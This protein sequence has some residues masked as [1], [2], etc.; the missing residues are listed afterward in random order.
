[1]EI[2]ILGP[3]EV[4]VAGSLVSVPR[5]QA[6]L[7]VAL[8]ATHANQV[9]SVGRITDV[10]W[11]GEPPVTFENQIQVHIRT[12]RRLALDGAASDALETRANLGYRLRTPPVA[13]DL[14]SWQRQVETAD[15][16]AAAG[17]LAEAAAAYRRALECWRGPA[18][19]GLRGRFAA[20]EA[21]VLEEGRM[22]VLL[23]RLDLELRL[24]RYADL[25]A[26]LTA[27]VQ[28]HPPHEG[29]RCRLM[30][31]LYGAGRAAEALATYRAGSRLL[32]DEHGV[33][34]GE[35]L[36][37]TH[38]EILAGAPVTQVVAG[39]VKITAPPAGPASGPATTVPRQLPAGASA[40]TGRA[41]D[42]DLLEK[43]ALDERVDDVAPAAVVAIVGM[44]GVGKTALAVRFGQRVA[45][46]FPDGQL[47]LDL[48]GHDPGTAMPV[49]EAL[50]RC[51]RA[52]G[53]Q[54]AAI[55]ADPDEAAA[56]YRSL[57]AGRRV[58]VVLDN[59]V[60]ADQVRP[61][62]PCTATCLAVV[63]SRHRLS[64]LV[65]R[66]GARRVAVGPLAAG[67]ALSLLR[68]IGGDHRTLAEPQAAA[69]LVE[70]TAGLPLALRIVAEK[71]A[72][73]P[74]TGLAD[75]VDS[76][77][78]PHRRLD[79][80]ATVDGD[81]TT[82]VRTAFSW[83]YRSLPADAASTYRTLGL[84]AG[85]DFGLPAAAELAGRSVSETRRQLELLA[86]AHLVVQE[87]PGERYRLHD[88]LR[89][90]AADLAR[91]GEPAEYR[92]GAV[93][94]VL[95][96]YCHTAAAAD[97]I[98][99]P[100]KLH[101][102]ANP[103]DGREDP[104]DGLHWSI[105]DGADQDRAMHWCETEHANLV[106]AVHQAHDLGEDDTAWRLAA[107]LWGY[108]YLR[109]PWTD[110]ITTYRVALGSARRSADGYGQAW[111]LNGLGVA[112]WDLRRFTEAVEFHR[113]ALMHWRAIGN[114]WGE[115]MTLNN[116]G[117]AQAGLR[118][119]VEAGD[120]FQQALAVRRTL[121]DRHG[122]AQTL[123]NLGHFYIEVSRFRH[124]IRC[125]EEAVTIFDEVDRPFGKATALHNLAAAA[126]GLGRLDDSVRACREALRLRRHLGDR[127]GV[128]DTLFLLGKSLA[129]AGQYAEA[130]ECWQDALAVLEK[131][132]DP[133]TAEVRAHISHHGRLQCGRR[134]PIY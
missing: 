12:L 120:T 2:R 74:G 61:L 125:C 109:K 45:D 46:R 52:L 85:P 118:R 56:T 42:L 107:S 108:F 94:R 72:A 112:H 132:E 43:F 96:W 70:L 49:A 19:D 92:A 102:P 119:F 89:C 32:A 41:V 62:L 95:R 1:M 22:A 33:D 65:A 73:L 34:P 104:G 53:M 38:A 25:V 28:A 13:V 50:A 48:R 101:P 86:A 126:Q 39:L 122:I 16:M 91:I 79:A 80:L 24:G 7:L 131:L 87:P 68:H 60:D 88:L 36:D 67:E 57:I 81:P 55:P 29:L 114:R 31:A 121:G 77:A 35:S 98:L 15:R 9:V 27:L 4:R 123:S 21:A 130:D 17:R 83:S 54:P 8:L 18:L 111:L 69:K 124:A 26:E 99:L 51:L 84:H 75:L 116:L 59:A 129:G 63:T 14:V 90:Y 103:A 23:R 127:Q 93:R 64:S 117:A 110:W 20:E 113:E 5:R 76:L 71:V 66:D 78:D 128:G 134:D 115:A 30:A 6:R 106:A 44:A 97:R 47:F 105:L 82:A 58:L 11:E 40:F 37:R 100:R 3:F 10:L 133:R